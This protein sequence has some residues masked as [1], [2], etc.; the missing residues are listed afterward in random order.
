MTTET[1]KVRVSQKDLWGAAISQFSLY[2]TERPAVHR[3]L[4]TNVTKDKAIEI[5]ACYGDDGEEAL[6]W[7]QNNPA[8]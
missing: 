2:Q 4:A 7:L 6:R 1:R 5:A 8:Q 3:F